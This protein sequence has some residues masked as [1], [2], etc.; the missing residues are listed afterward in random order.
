MKA[1]YPPLGKR[2]FPVHSAENCIIY[3]GLKREISSCHEAEGSL[4]TLTPGTLIFLPSPNDP[5]PG[6]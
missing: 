5:L 4:S 1:A 6:L 3:R 2:S